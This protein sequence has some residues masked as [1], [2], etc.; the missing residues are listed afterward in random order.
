MKQ[1]VGGLLTTRLDRMSTCGGTICYYWTNSFFLSETK[2]KSNLDV[3][4]K[5]FKTHFTASQWAFPE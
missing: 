3:P 1:K 5:Y 4:L 2:P